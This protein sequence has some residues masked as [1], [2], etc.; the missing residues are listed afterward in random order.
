MK[1]AV[2]AIMFI[3]ALVSFAFG[4]TVSGLVVKEVRMRSVNSGGSLIVQFTKNG[5]VYTFSKDASCSD[6]PIRL[7]MTAS[8]A[9]I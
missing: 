2:I 9:A 8:S 3:T 1:K 4:E 5:A 7:K 6:C